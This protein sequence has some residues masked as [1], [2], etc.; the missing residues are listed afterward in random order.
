MNCKKI[1]DIMRNAS[2]GSFP[3]NQMLSKELADLA[4]RFETGMPTEE[5]IRLALSILENMKS[6]FEVNL[7]ELAKKHESIIS[8][9]KEDLNA[10]D[11]ASDFIEW[12]SECWDSIEHPN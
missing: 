11:S 9:I 6:F 2:I 12:F 4:V 10:L 7:P 3:K 1:A 5:E 8:E